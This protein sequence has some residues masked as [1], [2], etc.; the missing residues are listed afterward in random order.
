LL[1]AEP[2]KNS[3]IPQPVGVSQD[4]TPTRPILGGQYEEMWAEMAERIAR[5]WIAR[6]VLI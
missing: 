5:E 1:G 6:P 2:T 4:E 3:R